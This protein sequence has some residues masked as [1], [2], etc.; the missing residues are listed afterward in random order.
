[1]EEEDRVRA[2]IS[3]QSFPLVESVGHNDGWYI[4]VASVELPSIIPLCPI[5]SLLS[6]HYHTL[7]Q[8]Q[9]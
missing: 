2:S 6:H 9:T 8:N 5:Q 3:L 7:Y 4:E 1:M